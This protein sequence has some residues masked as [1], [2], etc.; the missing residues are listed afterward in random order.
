MSS[1]ARAIV[2]SPAGGTPDLHV[3]DLVLGVGEPARARPEL[4]LGVVDP[5][6]C[7]VL[8]GGD[9]VGDVG[10]LRRELLAVTGLEDGK[11]R[12]GTPP[13]AARTFVSRST[14]ALDSRR[15]ATP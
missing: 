13:G 6:L 4:A 9:P 15:G 3:R 8:G 2:S 1:S 10:V 12:P 11:A 7:G 5:L 14:L